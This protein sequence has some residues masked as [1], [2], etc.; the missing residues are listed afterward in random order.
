MM[1]A[2]LLNLF[3]LYFE[4]VNSQRTPYLSFRGVL[5]PNNSYVEIS[6]IEQSSFTALSF[7][8]AVIHHWVNVETGSSRMKVESYPP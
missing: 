3:F 5:L 4:Q 7:K 8:T 6:S 1:L 2:V